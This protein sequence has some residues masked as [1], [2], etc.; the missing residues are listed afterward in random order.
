MSAPSSALNATLQGETRKLLSSGLIDEARALGTA[1]LAA[2]RESASGSDGWKAVLVRALADLASVE[3]KALQSTQARALLDEGISLASQLQGQAPLLAQLHLQL[4]SLIEASGDV[5]ATIAATEAAIPALEASSAE[6]Q[7]NAARLRNNLALTYK[8]QGRFALAEQHYLRSVEAIEAAVGRE[9]EEVASLYNNL[10]GLYLAAGFAEQAKEMFQEALDVRK[11]LLG[12]QHPDV[13][14]TL[15]NLAIACHEL[16]DSAASK[17]HFES[18]LQI[19]E[20][21]LADPQEA[22]S[23][24]AVGLD[25]V[26]LLN[27]LGEEAHAATMEQRLRTQLA[28]VA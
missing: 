1:A 5:E 2:A 22:A 12:A 4:T 27:A 8:R 19:L 7:L 18:A 11:P 17:Q 26:A 21:H 10:G 24:E 16:G 25:Y 23:Y 28:A 20:G 9:S 15:S 3:T 14:Q 6:D 13:S